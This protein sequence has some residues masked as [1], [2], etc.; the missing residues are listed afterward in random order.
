MNDTNSTLLVSEVSRDVQTESYPQYRTAGIGRLVGRT[1]I[2][3]A[4]HIAADQDVSLNWRGDPLGANAP[5]ASILRCSKY[6]QID[7]STTADHNS[8][9]FLGHT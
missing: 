8:S 3:S 5:P 2:D 1:E 4:R 6:F 9:H 7:R